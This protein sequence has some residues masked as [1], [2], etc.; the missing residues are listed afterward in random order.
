[1]RTVTTWLAVLALLATG[2]CAA[3]LSDPTG[4]H[5]AL[6]WAQREYTQ[7]V[8]WGDVQK[9]SEYIEEEKREEFVASAETF[10]DIRIT[11]FEI[12]AITY[13]GEDDDTA[14]VTVTYRAYS[15]AT[16]IETPIKEQQKWHRTEGLSN[17]WW[18]YSELSKQLARLTPKAP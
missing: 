8:R 13:S 16:L 7:R 1:M 14:E 15:L 17:D 12:G 6:E 4:K 3:T 10:E 2:G 11:D 18:V 9:A 5:N